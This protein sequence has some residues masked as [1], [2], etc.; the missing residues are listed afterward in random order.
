MERKKL[1]ISVR[2]PRLRSRINAY[3]RFP[4]LRRFT[5]WAKPRAEL[6]KMP[7]N[8][9]AGS[10]KVGNKSTG[11]V[12]LMFR[13]SSLV[14]KLRK[15]WQKTELTDK[16]KQST[17]T[18]RGSHPRHHPDITLNHNSKA[19]SF[20]NFQ[21]ILMYYFFCQFQV[22]S[23]TIYDNFVHVCNKNNHTFQY[24]RIL[25]LI[26][27]ECQFHCIVKISLL[28]NST[29]IKVLVNLGCYT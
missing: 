19:I 20:V 10:R 3:A 27:V 14:G 4:L 6:T 15:S 26:W 8:F 9:A 22:I 18:D 2:I 7:T 24:R 11:V 17:P 29:K 25:L 21:Y 16:T 23:V 13:S 5:A 1:G 12:S 28:H